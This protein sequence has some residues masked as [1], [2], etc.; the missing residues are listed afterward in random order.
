MKLFSRLLSLFCVFTLIFTLPCFAAG[1]ARED[2]RGVW[3]SSVYNLDYPVSATADSASLK[4]Q[5]DKILD[6]AQAMG[7]NAIF[8]QVRPSSDALYQSEIFPWSA[9]LTGLQGTAPSNSFDPLTYFIDGAHAR[10]MELHA[11]LNPYRITKGKDAEWIRLPASNP[12]KQHPELV[13]QH[14]GNY[15]YNPGL[16]AA[17]QLVLDGI[18]EIINRYPVDGIHLDDYFYPGTDFADSAAYAAYGN[19]MTLADWR[20]EN[21]NILVRSIDQLVHDK[22]PNLLFGISPSGVWE[23][24][25]ADARGSETRGGNPSYSAA[26]ADSLAWIKEGSIDYIC[27]QIYWY[28]GQSAADYQ[29]LL[30]WWSNAV[31]GSDVRLYIGEAAYKC[32][33]ASAGEV[34]KGSTELIRH[35]NLCAANQE[36]DGNIFFRYGSFDTVNGLRAALTSYYQAHPQK[37]QESTTAATSAA[38]VPL[39]IDPEASVGGFFEALAL[40]FTAVLR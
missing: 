32:D 2:M 39:Q 20:R 4:Q 34:W 40:F 16:P 11:W 17:R 31:T 13:V 12:A 6:G 22:N 27:P 25:S 3:V 37:V 21:V 14:G 30:N 23:N 1:N 5:A 15:Y 36:V 29:I 24:K 10:G 26:Y 19:G 38:D 18:A 28:I 35:M 9:Y 33:D 7:M 8:L